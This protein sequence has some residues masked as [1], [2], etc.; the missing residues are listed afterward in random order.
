M[1]TMPANLTRASLWLK[2]STCFEYCFAQNSQF[3]Y[4]FDH[5]VSTDRTIASL[6][7][8][9]SFGSSWSKQPCHPFRPC[10]LNTNLQ[11][12]CTQWLFLYWNLLCNKVKISYIVIRTTDLD[13]FFHLQV[14]EQSTH[15]RSIMSPSFSFNFSVKLHIQTLKDGVPE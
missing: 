3:K 5:F 12:S 6:F 14:V 7:R 10:H 9:C 13:I 8:P 11:I 15:G 4:C 2:R 1:E